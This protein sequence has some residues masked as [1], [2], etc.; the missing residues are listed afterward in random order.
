MGSQRFT[1]TDDS[2]GD[3]SADQSTEDHACPP[4]QD[5]ADH[6]IPA[7]RPTFVSIGGGLIAI[8]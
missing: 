7:E 4:Q 2:A 5:Q 8:D 6:G 3:E 1:P